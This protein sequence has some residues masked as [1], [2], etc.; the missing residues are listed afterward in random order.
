MNGGLRSAFLIQLTA[1]LVMAG[2]NWWGGFSIPWAVVLIPA[3]LPVLLW[4]AMIVLALVLACVAVVIR[5]A[6]ERGR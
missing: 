1:T 2:L 5:W 6:R 3:L 4:V